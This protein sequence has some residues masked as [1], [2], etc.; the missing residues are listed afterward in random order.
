MG[1][2]GTGSNRPGRHRVLAQVLLEEVALTP[3][4]GPIAYHRDCKL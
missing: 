1:V 3:T 2:T 4:L